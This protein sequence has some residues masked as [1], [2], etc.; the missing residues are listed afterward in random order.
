MT[1]TVTVPV[2]LLFMVKYICI[3]GG[4]VGLLLLCLFTYVGWRFVRDWK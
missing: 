3:A 1:I 2:W 4:V